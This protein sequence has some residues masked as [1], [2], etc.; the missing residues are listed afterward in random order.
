[1]KILMK[2]TNYGI[3]KDG[4]NLLP[5]IDIKVELSSITLFY[6]AKLTNKKLVIKAY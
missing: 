6:K 2:K 3:Q 5:T 4:T 1:M